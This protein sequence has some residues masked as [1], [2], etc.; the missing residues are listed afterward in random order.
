MLL[1]CLDGW[2]L[3]G[4][5]P[6]RKLSLNHKQAGLLWRIRAAPEGHEGNEEGEG[7][8]TTEGAENTEPGNCH[9][10]AQKYAIREF[11]FMSSGD[12]LW[13][14]FLLVVASGF[15]RGGTR[16]RRAAEP[17]PGRFDRGLQGLHG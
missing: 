10:E 8:L 11:L 7:R 14:P 17:E 9:K 13:R 1:T 16:G 4:S 6:M 3:V 12:F 5:Y 15:N 2:W